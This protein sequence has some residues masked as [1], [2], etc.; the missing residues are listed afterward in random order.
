METPVYPL[1]V[2]TGSSS[3]IGAATAEAFAAAGYPLLLLARRVQLSEA[4][5]LAQAT[6]AAVDVTDR[7][8]VSQ[9]IERAVEKWGPPDLLVNN[10]GIMPLGT[11]ESQE[12]AEW[13]RLFD[14]NCVGL[15][16]VT[17]CALPHMLRAGRGTIV[18]VGSIAGRNVYDNHMAYCGTKFA[19]HAMSEQMRREL[20]GRNIRV[21]IV[22]PGMVETELLESTTDA[23]VKADYLG[24]KKAIGGAIEPRHVAE[25]IL[26]MYRMPQEVCVR[27][28]V[29]APT[30][31][32]G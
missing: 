8:A 7:S 31:Q 30:C 17:R 32:E 24:Y 14:V 10:A 18:N 28:V 20:A 6:C 25:S 23:R 29:I 22:A 16:N 11:L 21:C 1:V 3:G 15:L 27:E 19:V 26:A 9:A 5:G 12:P 4:L 2:I 13:Q